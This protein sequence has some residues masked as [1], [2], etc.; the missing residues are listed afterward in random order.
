M[1]N[2]NV[3]IKYNEISGIKYV[4]TNLFCYL[5]SKNSAQH[6]VIEVLCQVH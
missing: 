6:V 2:T 3:P 4:Q 5:L 1:L